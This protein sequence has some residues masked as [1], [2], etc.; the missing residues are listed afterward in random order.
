MKELV[1]G[2]GE[3]RLKCWSNQPKKYRQ[4][5]MREKTSVEIKYINETN[6]APPLFCVSYRDGP[7]FMAEPGPSKARGPNLARP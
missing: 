7:E 5:D 6:Q 3:M 2:V 4:M 1:P